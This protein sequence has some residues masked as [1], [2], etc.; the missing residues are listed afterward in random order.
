VEEDPSSHVGGICNAEMSNPSDR[1]GF[2]LPGMPW[3]SEIEAESRIVT[4][5]WQARRQAA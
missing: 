1:P 3:F 2:I 5:K 4:R